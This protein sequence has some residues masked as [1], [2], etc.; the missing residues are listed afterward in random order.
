MLGLHHVSYT[1]PNKDLLFDNINLTINAHNKIA[2]IGNNG[3]GKS[4]LLRIVAGELKPSSGHI[5]VVSRPY[6]IPQIF[7]QYNHLTIAQALKIELKL[8]AFQAI[9]NGS[10]TEENYKFLA[11]DWTIE[12]R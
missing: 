2:L 8:T 11:D 4:T 12:A 7:G 3:S 6:Y 1:H 5:D 10:V 9:L